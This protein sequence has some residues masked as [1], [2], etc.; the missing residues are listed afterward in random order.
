MVWC[1]AILCLNSIDFSIVYSVILSH[2]CSWSIDDSSFSSFFN[3][4]FELLSE[5]R[6][7]ISAKPS[8]FHHYSRR[9]VWENSVNSSAHV[10]LT[11]CCYHVSFLLIF[12]IFPFL[13]SVFQMYLQFLRFLSHRNPY[14]DIFIWTSVYAASA[15][16]NIWLKRGIWDTKMFSALRVMPRS[17]TDSINHLF[18]FGGSFSE[19]GPVTITTDPKKFQYELRELYVQVGSGSSRDIR[20]SGLNKSRRRWSS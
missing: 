20:S 13:F 10:S 5:L 3:N 2:C 16:S 9:S 18:F 8:N 6:H 7:G 4:S 14:C 15:K 1:R 12:L 19:I 17:V 11:R